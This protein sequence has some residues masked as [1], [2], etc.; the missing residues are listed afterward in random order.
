MIIIYDDAAAMPAVRRRE[1]CAIRAK[2][3]RACGSEEA[4]PRENETKQ[5][6][7]RYCK[8][9]VTMRWCCTRARA[10]HDPN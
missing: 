7:E 3:P 6:A 8:R 2:M 5:N 9:V 4:T 10:R 1:A